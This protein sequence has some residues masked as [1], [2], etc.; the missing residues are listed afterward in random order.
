MAIQSK[1]TVSLWL[2][3]SQVWSY[4]LILPRRCKKKW[5]EQNLRR[6][7]C[8]HRV[9]LTSLMLFFFSIVLNADMMTSLGVAIWTVI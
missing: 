2:F 8:L 7:L 9:A 5:F 1:I 4:S 6:L 3:Y